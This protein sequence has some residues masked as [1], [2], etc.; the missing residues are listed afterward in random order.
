MANLL[1][2]QEAAGRLGVSLWTVYRLAR[3]GRL[4]SIQLGRRRLF[5]EEDLQE[6]V[7]S[8]RR[9]SATASIDSER[10]QLR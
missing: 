6:L 9:G 1:S 3:S 8:T 2:V 7:R 10:R 4:P 5:A